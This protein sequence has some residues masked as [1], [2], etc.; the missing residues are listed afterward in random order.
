MLSNKYAEVFIEEVNESDAKGEYAMLALRTAF[1]VNFE[2]YKKQFNSDFLLDFSDAIKK[3]EKYLD[4]T[5]T[6]IKIKD[7]YLYVQNSIL[8]HFI[9]F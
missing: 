1:G 4:I 9:N 7:E 3:N 6:T 8:V 2:E 5:K